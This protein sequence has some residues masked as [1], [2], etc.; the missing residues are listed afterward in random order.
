MNTLRKYLTWQTKL[1]NKQARLGY[2]NTEIIKGCDKMENTQHC[3]CLMSSTKLAEC[4]CML[5][6][7][8]MDYV[9][10]YNREYDKISHT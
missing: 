4:P 10:D 2:L 1:V 6:Y 3:A 8:G 7:Y 5:D 9:Y